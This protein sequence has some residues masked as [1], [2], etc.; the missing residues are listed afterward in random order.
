MKGRNSLGVVALGV[1]LAATSAFLANEAASRGAGCWGD[2]R[3]VSAGIVSRSRP[4]EPS[5]SL[6]AR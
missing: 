5:S 3:V 1:M 2:A 6:T 4:A